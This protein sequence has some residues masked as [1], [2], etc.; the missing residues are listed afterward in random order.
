MAKRSP[1][2]QLD[3]ALQAM[4]GR[5]DSRPAPADPDLATL[6]RI[7]VELRDLPGEAFKARL[8]TDLERKAAMTTTIAPATASYLPPGFRSIAPYLV[9]QGASR[10]L[11]FCQQAF[12]AQVKGR[13]PLP[14]GTLMHAEIQIGDSMVEMGDAGGQW[15]PLEAALHLYVPDADAVYARAMAAGATSLYA[16]MDQP[17]GD[18]EGGITDPSGNSWYIA[19][20]R[21]TGLAPEGFGSVTIGLQVQGSG[22]LLDFVKQAFGA[23]EAMCERAPDGNVRHAVLRIGDAMMEL[24][25]AHGPFGPKQCG[26]HLYVPD[27]DAV[28]ERALA[29]GGT[30]IYP[31]KDQP[32][33]ERSGGVQD[34]WG[35][36]WYIATFTG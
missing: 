19:T 22:G 6:L 35:N 14:D 12:G 20:H 23:E 13:V 36:Q 32:Y 8:R 17:Y 21:A 18:R 27:A 15:A 28:Y 33:G 7:A 3:Q 2:E 29:A 11:D 4:L 30:S 26:I 25:E 16:P 24:G 10:L 5:A 1:S 9:V 31:M 34:A